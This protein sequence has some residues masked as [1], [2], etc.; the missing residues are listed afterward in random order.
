M[1]V[2]QPASRGRHKQNGAALLEFAIVVPLLFLLLFGIIEAAWAFNQQLEVR[3]GARE[4]A[5]L[6]AVNAG[7][8][9]YVATEVCDRMHFSGDEAATLI[10]ISTSGS[11]IG[12]TATV[13]I[14]APYDGL[15]GFFDGVF[16]GASF[17]STVEIRLEQVPQAGLGSASP[18]SA[19]WLREEATR[20]S[21]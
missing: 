17:D 5:R 15:T 7:D 13:T 4:G 9:N 14:V 11:A 21:G 1:L 12:D 18:H 2:G 10:T 3:H 20:L 8:D 16:G 6:V 19:P